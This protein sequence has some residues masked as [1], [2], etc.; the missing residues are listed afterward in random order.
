VIPAFN[1]QSF[2]AETI[3]SA[4]SQDNVDL[5][6]VVVDDG[7]RDETVL[8]VRNYGNRVR[9]IEKPNGGVASARNVG[10]QAAKGD[11]I[12]LLDQDDRFLPGKLRRQVEVM[13]SDQ[14]VVLCHGNVRI[15]DAY[16]NCAHQPDIAHIAGHGAPSGMVL[17]QLLIWNH[18]L[19]CTTLIR[20]SS[21]LAVGAFNECLWGTDDY[22]CWLRLAAVGHFA[23]LDEELSEY[24]W[25]GGNAS[26]DR[27]RMD[28]A[29]YMARHV[30]LQSMPAARELI[31]RAEVDRVM[32][33]YAVDFGY[34]LMIAGKYASAR[35]V[36]ATGMIYGHDRAKLLKIYLG[37]Y[38]R[39]LVG[40]RTG[41][42]RSTNARSL[43]APSK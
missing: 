40:L 5:E 13:E 41:P 26:A 23:Y 42:A 16:G 9:L 30:F 32:A 3:E 14:K 2:I 12:A 38:L 10:V 21:L 17:N 29:R 19:A 8:L 27:S 36:V 20:R 31:G 28:H 25:H 11:Y 43:R 6:V 24:R 22:E 35:E 37:S 33:N 15:I 18:V 39:Q 1:G 7:S 4:L 34:A